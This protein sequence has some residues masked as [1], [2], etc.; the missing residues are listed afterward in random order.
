MVQLPCGHRCSDT[1]CH[2]RCAI[3]NEGPNTAWERL[4]DFVPEVNYF[5]QSAQCVHKY[6]TFMIHEIYRTP[7][8]TNPADSMVVIGRSAIRLGS[9][10]Q[11]NIGLA[12]LRDLFTTPNFPPLEQQAIESLI[13]VWNHQRSIVANDVQDLYEVSS[14]PNGRR[15]RWNNTIE[16][17][18]S[19]ESLSKTFAGRTLLKISEG[20]PI[21]VNR[22]PHFEMESLEGGSIGGSQNRWKLLLSRVLCF[23]L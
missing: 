14:S 10:A 23:W 16:C 8:T 22:R 20:I 15:I 6:D 4:L 1:L 17:E 3:F 7:G 12:L 21:E 11:T 19:A 2:L 18:Y 13:K 9:L 5:A